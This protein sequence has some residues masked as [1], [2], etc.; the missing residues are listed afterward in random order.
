MHCGARGG[1]LDAEDNT[2]EER[3]RGEGEGDQPTEEGNPD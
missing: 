2:K 3:G 1:W